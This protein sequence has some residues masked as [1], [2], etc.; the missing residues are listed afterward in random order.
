MPEEQQVAT[1]SMLQLLVVHDA[2]RED[3]WRE[4]LE[5]RTI[6]Y[7]FAPSFQQDGRKGRSRM[8]VMR[9]QDSTVRAHAYHR[10]SVA[11]LD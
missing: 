10:G 5:F 3:L 9:L 11:Q 2:P 1:P 6:L 7:T 8:L 4:D